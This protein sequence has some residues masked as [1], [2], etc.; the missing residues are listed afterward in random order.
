MSGTVIE[1]NVTSLMYS[2]EFLHFQIQKQFKLFQISFFP[3]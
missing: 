1:T 2:D 3:S